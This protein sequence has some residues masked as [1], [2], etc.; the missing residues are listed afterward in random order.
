M[1][2]DDFLSTQDPGISEVLHEQY[3][4]KNI[5]VLLYFVL[6]QISCSVQEEDVPMSVT[7]SKKEKVNY[8]LH[9]HML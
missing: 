9:E 8:N 6:A 4:L 5:T 3:H 2:D 1:G 7:K